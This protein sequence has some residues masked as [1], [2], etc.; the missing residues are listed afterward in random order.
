M[1]I[2]QVMLNSINLAKLEFRKKI[3]TGKS[4]TLLAPA[5]VYDQTYCLMVL[6]M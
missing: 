2:Q 1:F 6:L 5:I 3:T 4:G